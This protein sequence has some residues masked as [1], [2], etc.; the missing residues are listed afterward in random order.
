MSKTEGKG[1]VQTESDGETDLLMEAMQCSSQA[2][3]G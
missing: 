2:A 3:V 1:L